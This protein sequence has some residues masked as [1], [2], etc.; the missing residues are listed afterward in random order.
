[1]KKSFFAL[2]A[3]IILVLLL[4][5]CKPKT[6]NQIEET[7]AGPGKNVEVK[8]NVVD[9]PKADVKKEPFVLKTDKKR[10]SKGGSLYLTF[11]NNFE[12]DVKIRVGDGL[13]LFKVENGGNVNYGA[14]KLGCECEKQCEQKMN[15]Y[16]VPTKG[17]TTIP[18]MFNLEIEGLKDS[19]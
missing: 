1:M 19:V 15:N 4:I 12:K 17:Q 7:S 6:E 9:E 5:G 18:L 13:S 3:I 10:Y 2:L 8:V 14:T 11:E 16:D